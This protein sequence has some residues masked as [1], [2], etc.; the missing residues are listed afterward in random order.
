MINLNTKRNVG[1][2]NAT[3]LRNEL[4]QKLV[5]RVV[6]RHNV[7][8]TIDND[9]GYR[10]FRSGPFTIVELIRGDVRVATGVAR[11]SRLDTNDDRAGISIAL[12]RALE[13]YA[14]RVNR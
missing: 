2:D 8:L 5:N 1:G 3:S 4:G 10:A 9:L 7:A 13:D 11:K 6:K 14:K 12:V